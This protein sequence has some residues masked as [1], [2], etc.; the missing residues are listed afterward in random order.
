MANRDI[1]LTPSVPV[2]GSGSKSIGFN[3]GKNQTRAKKTVTYSISSQDGT[4]LNTMVVEQDFTPLSNVAHEGVSSQTIESPTLER[5]VTF[6]GIANGKYLSVTA[7]SSSAFTSVTC[8]VQATQQASE[9]TIGVNIRQ[10]VKVDAFEGG[11]S[12]YIYTLYIKVAANAAGGTYSFTVNTSDSATSQIISQGYTLNIN[13]RSGADVGIITN[14]VAVSNGITR[15]QI[16]FDV[17]Y[18]NTGSTTVTFS[19]T[20]VTADVYIEGSVVSSIPE[21]SQLLEPVEVGA[22][23]S[24]PQSYTIDLTGVGIDIERISNIKMTLQSSNI[25]GKKEYN[26]PYNS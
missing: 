17:S 4:S 8:K 1:S 15:P 12:S 14:S 11:L 5:E 7:P 25:S 21:E 24:L 23:D 16:T 10:P 22:S 3:W 26:I 9:Q 13:A 20:H 19:D 2:S 18:S 6:N